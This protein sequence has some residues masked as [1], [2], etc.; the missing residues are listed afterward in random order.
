VESATKGK[1]SL[2]RSRK[3]EDEI[4]RQGSNF[5]QGALGPELEFSQWRRKDKADCVSAKTEIQDDRPHSMVLSST[6]K[7][8]LDLQGVLPDSIP[9]FQ[10]ATH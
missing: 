1:T 10:N 8:L 6:C 4:L 2:A 5:G 7:E 9:H 3:F